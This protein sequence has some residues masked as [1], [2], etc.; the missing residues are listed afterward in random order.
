MLDIQQIDLLPFCEEVANPLRKV[1][2]R[3][4]K[5][6][7]PDEPVVIWADEMKMN[8]VLL[9][10]LDNALKY[11]KGKIEIYVSKKKEWAFIKIKDYGIGIPKDELSVIFER[12]YRV[13]KARHRETG[14]SG[15]GLSIA[16]RIVSMHF[17]KI[18]LESEE[19]KGTEVTICLPIKNSSKGNSEL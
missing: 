1:Y 11:S 15:L 10:L 18:K 19:R 17:G 9:I 3:E 8:Q 16:K 14:G 4:I 2:K 5:L 7:Y 6:I 13:D 12:F